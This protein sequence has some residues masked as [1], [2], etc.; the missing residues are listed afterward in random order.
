MTN[1]T[2]RNTKTNFT[3]PT[4]G[5]W[6]PNTAYNEILAAFET[7]FGDN[8][9]GPFAIY[10]STDWSQYMNQVFSISGGNHSGETLRTMLLKNPDVV[11]VERL[12]RLT[13][14]FTLIIQAMDRKYIRFVN[15]MDIRTWQYDTKGGMQKN[16]KA[17]VVQATLPL[18]DYSGRC[19]T[20]HGTTT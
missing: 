7:L 15:G 14:T 19:G 1:Y 16:F 8:V 4:A 2:N 12:D 13:S 11:S 10:H 6:V 18:S 3:A 9:F 17:G 20:L 5:G